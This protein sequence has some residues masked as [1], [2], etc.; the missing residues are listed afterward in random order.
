MAVANEAERNKVVAEIYKSLDAWENSCVPTATL[1]CNSCEF[2][3]LV[4]NGPAEK[5]YLEITNSGHSAL[6]FSFE[7]LPLEEGGVTQTLPSW[8]DLT[9]MANMLMPQEACKVDLTARV[10]KPHAA[11]LTEAAL[12][13]GHGEKPYRMEVSAAASSKQAAHHTTASLSLS[14]PLASPSPS[15]LFRR[16]SYSV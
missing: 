8:L 14:H 10:V 4:A 15:T 16:S 5:K 9:P 11:A 13:A 7:P 1:D 12:L 6:K 3:E 2:G